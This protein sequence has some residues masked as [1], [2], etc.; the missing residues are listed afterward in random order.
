MLNLLVAIYIYT[1]V[2]E[3]LM[4]FLV[5]LL[6]HSVYRLEKHGLE[7][8][9]EEGAAMLVVNHPSFVDALVI[10]AACRRPTRYVMDHNWFNT[11]LLKFLF[12]ATRSIPIASAKENPAMLE[13]A[14]DEI[15]KGLAEGDLICI[16]PEGRVTSDGE[17]NPFRAG[18]KRIID[19]TPVPVVPIALRGLWGSFFGRQGGALIARV[20]RL[21][22]FAKISMHVGA[23][24][25]ANVATPECLQ[26]R[27][28][29]LRGNQK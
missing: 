9:P 10:A 27:V 28:S 5:W 25:P 11:P 29:D 16:F 2:P 1:L 8:I 24:V 14:Y 17:I 3:F 20:F 7:N 26:Q 15:A 4:R 19:R 23:P 21:G 13:R 6:I 18:I 12:R 22:L